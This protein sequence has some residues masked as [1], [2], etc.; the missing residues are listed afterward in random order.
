MAEKGLD[1]RYNFVNWL[2]LNGADGATLNMGEGLFE[3]NEMLQDMDIMPANAEMYHEDL[4]STSIPTPQIVKIGDGWD[5]SVVQWDKFSDSLSIFRDRAQ[6]PEDMLRLGGDMAGKRMQV[7]KQH[8]EGFS[9]GVQNHLIYGSSAADPEKFDGLDVRYKTPDATD[10]W[11]PASAGNYGVLDMGGTG[12]DTTSIWLIQWGSEKCSLRTPKNDPKGGLK[13]EDMGRHM[14]TAENSKSRWDYITEFEWTLGLSIK[15]IRS[16]VRIRNIESA[17]SNVDSTLINKILEAREMFWGNEPVY[18]YT[19]RKMRVHFKILA[20][21]KMNCLYSSE[22]PYK[23]PLLMFDDMVV[24]RC[25]AI[26]NTET[27]V[28]AA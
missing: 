5:A 23:I 9:Q 18:M 1:S 22:N 7:E 3:N 11:S 15:D 2:K 8:V 14:V 16:V 21:D 27:A 26:L 20:K 28:A 17:I 13:R 25:D 4:R 6:F 10:P 19:N 24:R 12:S